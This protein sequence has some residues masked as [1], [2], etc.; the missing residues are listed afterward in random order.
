MDCQHYQFDCSCS[1]D[2]TRESG[3]LTSAVAVDYGPGTHHDAEARNSLRDP[4]E[5]QDVLSETDYGQ[6]SG[7]LPK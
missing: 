4:A 1:L 6:N 3:V 7:I 5:F 2:R